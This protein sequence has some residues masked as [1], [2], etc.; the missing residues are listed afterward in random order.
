MTIAGADGPVRGAEHVPRLLRFTT[1]VSTAIHASKLSAGAASMAEGEIIANN[2]EATD[3]AF[4]E[5]GETRSVPDIGDVV[6]R[7]VTD[8]MHNPGILFSGPD[9][10]AA[11]PPRRDLTARLGAMLLETAIAKV[12]LD[13]I[14]NP[15]NRR[16][17]VEAATRER[18]T[19]SGRSLS[20]RT[21]R[22]FEKGMARK[23]ELR[24][25]P[26]QAGSTEGN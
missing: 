15:T 12:T 20:A 10:V 4:V 17:S 3:D 18:L 26:P 6:I 13:E 7:F 25:T 14:T 21:Y 22:W 5:W 2:R 16:L 8:A 1:L 9:A 24:V 23:I 11:N 19:T